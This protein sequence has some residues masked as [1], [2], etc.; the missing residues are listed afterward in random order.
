MYHLFMGQRYNR[1]APVAGYTYKVFETIEAAMKHFEE[2]KTATD[3]FMWAEVFKEHP[4][5]R[6]QL[7]AFFPNDAHGFVPEWRVFED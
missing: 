7:V 4:G 3:E 6:L 2:N 5:E 1:Y